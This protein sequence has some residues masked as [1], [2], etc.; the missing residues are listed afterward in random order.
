[1]LLKLGTYGLVRFW[2]PVAD[3]SWPLLAPFVAGLAVVGIVYAALAC[4]AQTD[5]KRLI[6]YSSVGHM[7]F[8]VLAVATF[9]V[10]GVQ[11][12]VYASVAHGLIT[13][14]LFFLAGAIK[15]RFDTGDLARLTV[16]YGSLPRLA[17]LFAFAS[18]A[19]LGLPGLAGFWGEML[20]I[21]SA[22]YPD[23]ALPGP[24]YAT[25]AVVAALGVILTSAYFLALMRGMLQGAPV[26]VRPV[27]AGVPS[28]ELATVEVDPGT[29]MAGGLRPD[30]DA[31]EW[32]TWSPLVVLTL[33][34][35]VAP[36]LLLGPVAVAAR[37]FLGGLS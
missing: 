36:G 12:A 5:L 19:S 9:T 16:L 31:A 25:L 4:L 35:G 33:V 10:G 1:V 28:I 7:G 3:P 8:V 32:V 2:M 27:N 15:E 24:T 22:V 11:A 6:A 34:L 17:G 14:L 21:R 18:M 37:S 26:A 20:S 30:V 23:D 13:G 29:S